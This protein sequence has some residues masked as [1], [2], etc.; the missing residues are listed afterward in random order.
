MVGAGC[1]V[2][3]EQEQ[4]RQ[5]LLS[6]QG[7]QDAILDLAVH[8]VQAERLRASHGL[9]EGVEVELT[10]GPPSVCLDRLSIG[11]PV[12]LEP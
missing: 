3:V 7:A 10:D 6:V 11:F 1:E 8:E 12:P 4:R 9:V 5:P 2:P